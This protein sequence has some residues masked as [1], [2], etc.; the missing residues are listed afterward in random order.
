MRAEVDY[1]IARQT[2]IVTQVD[3]KSLW[4]GSAELETSKL[5]VA[6]PSLHHPKKFDRTAA[7]KSVLRLEIH[8]TLVVVIAGG[9]GPLKILGLARHTNN[10]FHPRFFGL[11]T[12]LDPRGTSGFHFAENIGGLNTVLI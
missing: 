11:F 10:G 8:M 9:A 4:F 6:S 5:T 1:L 7:I 3:A 12:R 2:S